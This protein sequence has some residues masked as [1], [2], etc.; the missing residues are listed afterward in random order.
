MGKPGFGG[1]A[2]G[3]NPARAEQGIMHVVFYSF[4]EEHS[5]WNGIAFGR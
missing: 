5:A 3:G 2:P 1:K 4:F